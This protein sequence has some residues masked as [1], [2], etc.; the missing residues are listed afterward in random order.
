[1][2]DVS[3]SEFVG[4][5]AVTANI[6]IAVMIILLLGERSHVAWTRVRLQAEE[7]TALRDNLEHQAGESEQ[8]IAEMR[9]QISDL[10]GQIQRAEKD[11]ES[12]QQ[13]HRETDLPLGYIATPVDVV[14]RRYRTWR[15]VVRN[16]DLG[17]DAGSFSHPAHRWIEGRLYEIPAPNLDYAVAAMEQRFPS[18][19]GFEVEPVHE[20]REEPVG[21]TI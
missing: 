8:V 12:L 2:P 15:V 20:R 7:M 6:A 17:A 19:E 16:P 13:R 1:M 14:D 9:E 3:L 4:F 11:L 21:A 18:R 5:L 10:R